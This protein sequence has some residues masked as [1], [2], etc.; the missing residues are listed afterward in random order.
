MTILPVI[1]AKHVSQVNSMD[2]STSFLIN[3]TF[4]TDP[5]VN[6][7]EKTGQ[8]LS[9]TSLFEI[10]IL[11]KAISYNTSIKRFSK[12]QIEIENLNRREWKLVDRTRTNV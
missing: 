3:L 8:I 1:T 7:V 5:K 9:L 11:E 10:E 2:S 4:G 6:V 12:L